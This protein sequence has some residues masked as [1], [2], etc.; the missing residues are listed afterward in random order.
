MGMDGNFLLRDAILVDLDPPNIERGDLRVRNGLIVERG[1]DLAPGDEEVVDVEGDVILPG[2]VNAHMHLYSALA[3]GMPVPDISNFQQALDEVWWPLDRSLD[4]E[5]VRCSAQIGLIGALKAGCTTVID[6]HASPNA[7]RGSLDTIAEEAGDI[8]L[9]TV[10]SYELTDRNGRGGLKVG[11]AENADAIGRYSGGFCRA[12]AG[13]HAGFTLSD[14]ALSQVATLPGPIHIHVGEGEQDVAYAIAQGDVGPVARLERHGLLR[15]DS[16]LVH[17]V[18]LSD[19]EVARATEAGAWLVHNPSSNRNNRVGY[20]KPGRFGNR[21]ALGTDGIGSDMFA[22]AKDAFFAAREH[23]HAVDL[24]GLLVGNHRLA[25]R[26]LDV[27]LG[28]L[29]EGFC[30]DFIRLKM[31]ISTPLNRD[32]L[33][34]HLLFGFSANQVEDVWVAGQLRLGERKVLGVDERWMRGRARRLSRHLWEKTVAERTVQD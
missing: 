13:L 32:N 25:S 4:L 8:G 27:R 16:L 12:I 28:Q 33:F 23:H 19:E 31:A 15:P 30:A 2:M 26:L 18:H 1:P 17:G 7:I 6:H 34:G 21:G 24:I 22:S 10:L 5:D 20:A 9:R 14:A 29:R 3:V 11:L